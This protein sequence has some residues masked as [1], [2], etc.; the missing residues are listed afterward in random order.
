MEKHI[1]LA[2]VF[3][4]LEA[5]AIVR[6]FC[7]DGDTNTVD[8]IRL[9]GPPEVAAVITVVLD[10][11][12]VSKS[13]GGKLRD[14]KELKKKES[15]A[16]QKGFMWAVYDARD[17][18]AERSLSDADTARLIQTKVRAVPPHMFDVTHAGCGASCPRKVGN[19]CFDAAHVP[20]GLTSFIARGAAEAT[21]DAVVAVFDMYSSDEFSGKLVMKGSTNTC[22]SGN[23]LLW[24]QHLPKTNLQP[25]AAPRKL[26]DAQLQ[27]QFGR[28]A[29]A[30]AVRASFGG[31]ESTVVADQGRQLDTYI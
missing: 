30:A 25:T 15:A 11:N 17:E 12:H 8:W 10:G 22:E 28:C 13:V 7:C 18:A 6:A 23:S 16:L 1:V 24:L 26:S 9:Y 4:L 29:G 19:A 2:G 3:A 14:V 21:Y 20:K 27:K 31:R 5:G